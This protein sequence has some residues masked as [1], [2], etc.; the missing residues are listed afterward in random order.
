MGNAYRQLSASGSVKLRTGTLKGIICLASSAG[1]L[2]VYD[3]SLAASGTVLIGPLSLTAGQVID[4][5]GDGIIASNGIYA[6][7][8][9]TS[10]T[11]NVLFE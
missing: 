11:V 5:P 9:G 10:A 8:G 6:A 2:T 1:T 4:I 3:N 7:I